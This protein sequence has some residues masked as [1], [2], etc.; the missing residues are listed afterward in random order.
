MPG[1]AVVDLNAGYRLPGAAFFRN[2]TLRL[3]VS[4][5]FDK[6]YLVLTGPSGSL[7]VTN[8]VGAGAGTPTFFVGAPRFVSASLS[9]EF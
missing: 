9:A 4:N 6:G 7:F 1:Y 5:L 8:T 2:P 3:S